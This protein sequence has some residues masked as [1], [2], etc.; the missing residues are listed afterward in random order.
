VPSQET[1]KTELTDLLL[2]GI[3]AANDFAKSAER[4][5]TLG[6]HRDWW[7]NPPVEKAN[8]L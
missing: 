4:D 1:N 6:L 7:R 2:E 8:P 5:W 3:D